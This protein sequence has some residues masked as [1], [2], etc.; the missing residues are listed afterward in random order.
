MDQIGSPLFRGQVRIQIVG[1]R[2]TLSMNAGD[3]EKY[4]KQN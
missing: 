2:G 4:C 1:L 3:R